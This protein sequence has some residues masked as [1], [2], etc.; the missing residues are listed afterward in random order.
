MKSYKD[1]TIEL[2]PPLI[3]QIFPNIQMQ[4][5]FLHQSRQKYSFLNIFSL[6]RSI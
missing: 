3:I 1:R 2:I 6:S 4:S 5:F